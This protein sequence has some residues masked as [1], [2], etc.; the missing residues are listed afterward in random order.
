MSRSAFKSL[1]NKLTGNAY[2]YYDRVLYVLASALLLNYEMFRF[3]P[4]SDVVVFPGLNSSL[5]YY[6]A[7][8]VLLLGNY[9]FFGTFYDLW[10]S[11]VFGFD[12]LRHFR[13]EGT[14][15]PV[16]FRMKN[17]SRLAFSCRH[18]LMTGL[19]CILLSSL[20]YGPISLGRAQFVASQMVA[21][22]LGIHFEERE[23]RRVGGR[24]F[25]GFCKLIPNLVVPDFSLFFISS[26]EFSQLQ[27]RFREEA[28]KVE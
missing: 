10:Y 27:K 8:F 5:A 16:P 23:L 19:Y 3:N 17:M 13:K 11:D 14:E 22:M 4:I 26:E 9:Y 12:H 6:F 21:V 7:I 15:F 1:M 28:H 20:L 2:Y 25:E 18:P 24:E